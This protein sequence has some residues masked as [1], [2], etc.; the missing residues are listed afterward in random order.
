MDESYFQIESGEQQAILRSSAEKLG[1]AEII[2]E[3]DI[4]LCW[5]LKKLFGMP[6]AHPMAFKGGTSLSKVFNV[7]N[8]FSED[9]DIT[10]DY[11]HFEAFDPFATG[12]SG[13]KIKRFSQRLKDHVRTYAQEKV[14][15]YLQKEL[16]ILTNGAGFAV[17]LDDASGEK[18]WVEY[19]SVIEQSYG[20]LKEEVLVELGG[21][22]VIDPNE[23]HLVRPYVGDLFP[24]LLFPESRVVVLS[25]ERTFWEKATLIHVECNRGV[26]ETAERLS[27]HWYDLVKLYRHDS[28]QRALANREL[29]AEV[30]AH[31]SIFY[32]A[33]YADYSA[34]LNGGIRLLP[35]EQGRK[36]LAV[37]YQ[38]MLDA[39]MLY[40]VPL[41]IED[42]F[43]DM[44]KIADKINR[45]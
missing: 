30:V 31:K 9:V 4:W 19:P 18:I 14:V 41:T 22:N 20:Y 11:R 15:P 21:R 27:R 16:D 28:G 43:S 37:D 24:E 29:L 44:E 34:C 17:R 12:V 35:D 1:R 36:L 39:E 26:R 38:K 33:S 10:L 5:V 3:K 32:H 45:R 7:I 23:T 42:I 8:R 6:D 2:L 25:P 13:A 40:E